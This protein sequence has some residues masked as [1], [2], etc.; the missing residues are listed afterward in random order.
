MREEPWRDNQRPKKG[1][2]RALSSLSEMIT[3]RGDHLHLQRG[4]SRTGELSKDA[5]PRTFRKI[6]VEPRSFADPLSMAS[7]WQ[8]P[9]FFSLENNASS[10]YFERAKINYCVLYTFAGNNEFCKNDY[11]KYHIMKLVFIPIILILL[12]IPKKSYCAKL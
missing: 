2:D 8:T 10:E 3:G 6:R 5:G 4:T 9:T 11:W 7:Y 12:L 1:K